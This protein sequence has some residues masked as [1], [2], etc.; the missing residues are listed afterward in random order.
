MRPLLKFSCIKLMVFITITQGI[1]M[2]ILVD[3]GA[4]ADEEH[5]P[6]EEQG[7]LRCEV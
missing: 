5:D 7:Q 1:V 4:I 2:S 3:A 6:A